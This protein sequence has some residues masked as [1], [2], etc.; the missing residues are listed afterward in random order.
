MNDPRTARERL[1]KM[2]AAARQLPRAQRRRT[3]M[4][5]MHETYCRPIVAATARQ[6][7]D[8]RCSVAEIFYAAYGD[9]TGREY[10]AAWMVVTLSER[11]L[12]TLLATH[13]ASNERQFQVRRREALEAIETLPS[14][15]Q[16]QAVVERLLLDRNT[17]HLIPGE[18]RTYLDGAPVAISERVEQATKRP[19]QE[20]VDMSM[21]LLFQQTRDA[22]RKP[23]RAYDEAFPFC[24]HV[25]GGTTEQLRRALAL[26]PTEM[27]G[28][29]GQH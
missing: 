24:K 11:E 6:E 3:V 1:L 4:R 29:R 28:H 19:S 27:R 14:G 15:R 7:P 18:L 10:W 16:A 22:G 5:L 20:E 8:L 23:P 12:A 13:T 21:L 2:A 9:G 25:T 17:E 26:V